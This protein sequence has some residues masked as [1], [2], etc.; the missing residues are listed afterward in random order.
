MKKEIFYMS[1]LVEE[2]RFIG[3]IDERYEYIV[4]VN[5]YEFK[6]FT[7]SG[8]K[9][10]NGTRK[11]PNEMTILGCLYSDAQ[12]GTELFKDFCDNLGYETDSR[13]ALEMYLQCQ[14]IAIKLRG[15]DWPQQII[16]GD[17]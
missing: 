3:F 14:D 9:N 17:Y 13:K 1:K 7:G 8:H 12:L 16:E 11:E 15:F 5:G 4:T 10:K 6:F 2:I